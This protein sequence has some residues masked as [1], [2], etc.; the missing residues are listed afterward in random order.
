[1]TTIGVAINGADH[2]D[3]LPKF[4]RPFAAT[5]MSWG[6]LSALPAPVAVAV[7]ALLIGISWGVTVPL[8]G[9]GVVAPHWFYIP[10]FMAG[11]RFGPFGALIAGGASMYV[12]GPLLPLSFNP[13]VQQATSDWVSRGI[14]FIVIG[15][16]V[17]L[18]FGVVRQQSY[19]ESLAQARIREVAAAQA[20]LVRR[21]RFAAVGEMATVIGHEL[22]N[23]L[24]AAINLLFLARSRLTD[25]DDP[26]LED[27][28]GRAEHEANRA[29]AL[30]ED[31]ALFM[32]E[33]HWTSWRSISA[34]SWPMSSNRLRRHRKSRCPSRPAGSI[35]MAT[36]VKLPRCFR[37][38][39]STPIRPWLTGV[40]CA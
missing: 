26:E 27:Y 15:Q 17:T 39:S 30:S 3:D 19:A 25:H 38:S 13:T 33:P 31:L 10:I 37:D 22:R 16:F 23:P 18:L 29:A 34:P 12:A 8:G 7:I 24:G 21:E 4:K 36:E 9:A 20:D 32:R 11:L 2:V 5:L 6:T 40:P 28:L 35:C 14:F 1:M